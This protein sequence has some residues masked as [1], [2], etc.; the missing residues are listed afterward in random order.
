MLGQYLE[1][2]VV[3]DYILIQILHMQKRDLLHF[4]IVSTGDEL[5]NE[6]VFTVG[7]TTKSDMRI[8]V[9]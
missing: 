9:T 3:H 2:F 1:G 4:V 5:L 6:L 8:F 7:T